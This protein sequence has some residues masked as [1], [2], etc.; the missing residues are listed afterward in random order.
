M[1]GSPTVKVML[2]DDYEIVREGLREV[3]EGAGSFAVVGQ[4]ADGQMAVEMASEL[5]PTWWL[6]T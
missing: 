6:W 3:L 4:A 5:R 2:V 1:A